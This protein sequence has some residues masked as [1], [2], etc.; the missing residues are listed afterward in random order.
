MCLKCASSAQD[1]PG[2]GLIT[3]DNPLYVASDGITVSLEN[4]N[5]NKLDNSQKW[6]NTFVHFVG[7]NAVRGK[8]TFQDKCVQ[9]L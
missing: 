5:E 3:E 1:E 2:N 7:Q 8:C 9:L 6:K 4:M